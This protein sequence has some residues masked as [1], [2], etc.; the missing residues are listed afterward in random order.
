MHHNP[1]KN[2]NRKSEALYIQFALIH[3]PNVPGSYAILLFADVL[4]IGDK[5]DI[6]II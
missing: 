3:G 4:E 6:V 5:G 1:H 2:P